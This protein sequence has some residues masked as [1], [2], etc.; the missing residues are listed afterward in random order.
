MLADVVLL[1]QIFYHVFH[2]LNYAVRT[3]DPDTASEGYYPSEKMRAYSYSNSCAEMVLIY[4]GEDDIL[5]EAVDQYPC[6]I[7]FTFE[8]DLRF[9]ADI[10]AEE[11]FGVVRKVELPLIIFSFSLFFK[12]RDLFHFVHTIMCDLAVL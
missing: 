5:A 11:R 3:D 2:L 1:A 10:H 12:D 4:R 6:H 7:V 8:C 9:R